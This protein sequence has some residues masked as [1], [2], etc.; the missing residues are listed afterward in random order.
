M[1]TSRLLNVHFGV[2][3]PPPAGPADPLSEG[4]LWSSEPGSAAASLSAA[5]LSPAWRL[6]QTP[7][8][9]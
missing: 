2:Y 4:C 9:C 1:E 3:I 7:G 8:R 5:A 6:H